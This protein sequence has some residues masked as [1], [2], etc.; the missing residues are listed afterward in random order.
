ME[1]QMTPSEDEADLLGSIPASFSIIYDHEPF[2][3]FR[4]CMLEFTQCLWSQTFAE[5][6]KIERISD[7]GFSRIVGISR[8]VIE[9]DSS[10]N[11]V[12][13]IPRFDVARLDRDVVAL[14]FVRELD[15]IPIAGVVAYAATSE[16]ILQNPNIVQNRLS[17]V[18]PL[19]AFPELSHNDRCRVASELGHIFRRT[20]AAK[21]EAA[22]LLTIPSKSSKSK[23]DS[24]RIG[25]QPFFESEDSA[26]NENGPTSSTQ[27][28]LKTVFEA[29]KTDGQKNSP[30]DT[31]RSRILTDS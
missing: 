3:T 2:E 24:D 4:T 31:L 12:L 27:R 20:L 17:G 29:R 1:R 25:I 15:G 13:R 7:G 22:G 6:M 9:K 10:L 8:K 30:A 16:N 18:D 11:Y 19:S 28:L 23:T 5:Y 26:S 14:H 21:S